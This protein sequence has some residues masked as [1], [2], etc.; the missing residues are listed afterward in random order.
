MQ[1]KHELRSELIIGNESTQSRMDN[2][3]KSLMSYGKII[4]LDETVDQL[5]RVTREEICDFMQ[6]WADPDNSSIC[7]MGN[8]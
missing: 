3:A 2:N 7:V 5:M 4:S 1:A 6:H 8:Y